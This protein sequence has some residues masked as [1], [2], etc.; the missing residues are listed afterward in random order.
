MR[1]T[2]VVIQYIPQKGHS[3]MHHDLE[4]ALSSTVLRGRLYYPEFAVGPAPTVIAHSGIGSVAEGIYELAPFFTEVGLAVLFY[5]HRGFGYSDGEP[6]QQID[7]WQFGRDMREV[8]TI[9]GDRDDVDENRIAPWG[10]SLGGLVS[11][12]VAGTDLRVAAVVASVP[13]ISGWAARQLFPAEA[14][15]GL[16][17]AIAADRRA[18][19]AGAAPSMLQTT[20]RRSP[21]G[22]PVMFTDEEGIEF[23]AHYL[24]LPSFRNELT[25]S[26][27]DRLFEMEVGVYA[28][29]IAAPLFMILATDDTVAPVEDAREMFARVRSEKKL[30][31][32]PGQHYG[33][34]TAQYHQIVQRTAQWLARILGTQEG[35]ASEI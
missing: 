6:R 12:F 35:D 18:Q 16:D 26:S 2:L 7:P 20:G 8:I 3:P 17:E 15:A 32:Y 23:T 11:L 1:S 27:L 24:K 28:E 10:I 21:D 33:I 5:D 14:L 30:A 19:L 29:R 34:L 9:L 13:P 4:F 31:E 25:L 22:P